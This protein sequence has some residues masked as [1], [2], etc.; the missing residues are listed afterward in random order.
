MEYVV[1]EDGG[2]D[3]I[4]QGRCYLGREGCKVH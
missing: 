3:G 1:D 2:G 4:D